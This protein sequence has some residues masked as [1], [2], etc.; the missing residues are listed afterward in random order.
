ADLPNA[1][2]L[3][4]RRGDIAW[5]VG[6]VESAERYLK[7]CFRPRS[8]DAR[9]T[10]GMAARTVKPAV[11]LAEV[12]MERGEFAQAQRYVDRALSFE[13]TH[14]PAQVLAVRAALLLGDVNGATLG[15]AELLE[16]A[17]ECTSVR[18]L[19]GELAWLQGDIV[20]AD[21]L[22]DGLD[23]STDQGNEAL[24]RKAIAAVASGRLT[25]ARAILPNLVDRDISAAAA[26]L[27]VSVVCGRAWGRGNAFRS[28]RLMQSLIG[29][30]RELMCAEADDALTLFATNSVHYAA[31]LPGIEMLL[32]HE[33]SA[34]E[35]GA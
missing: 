30:L 2:D 18:L 7:A 28:E 10:G 15:L 32:T 19:G 35:A 16:E 12:A 23:S 13:P 26:R 11:R 1:V 21:A 34:A 20:G 25:D 6:D 33:E 27:M 4:W 31:D 5:R 14:R 17:P 22:W 24:C 9:F 3:I 8:V 29:W